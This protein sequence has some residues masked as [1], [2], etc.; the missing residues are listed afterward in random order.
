MFASLLIG[1]LSLILLIYWFRYSCLLILRGHA[2]D[3]AVSEDVRFH[4]LD[5]Q[6][7]LPSDTDLN[8]LHRSLQQD[9]RLLTYLFEH[10]KSLGAPS[11]EQRLLKLDYQLMQ[12]WFRLTRARAP[13]QARLALTE[14]TNVVAFLAQRMNE[15]AGVHSQI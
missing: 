12:T 8:R 7:R 11:I 1:T 3:N 5:V 2:S 10:A 13:Q 15:Q 9:F 6:K 14:M 4:F